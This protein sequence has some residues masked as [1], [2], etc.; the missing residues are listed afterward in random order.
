MMMMMMMVHDDTD[1]AKK[2]RQKVLAV[3]LPY[4]EMKMSI[5][6]TQAI[7]NKRYSSR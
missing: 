1:I 6:N 7:L 5:G 2:N 3:S 4:L